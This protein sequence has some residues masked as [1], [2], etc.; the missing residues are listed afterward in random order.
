MEVDTP[1][2]WNYEA[3][4]EHVNKQQI[5]GFESPLWSETISSSKD[6]EYLSFPRLMG[7]AEMGWS[8]PD[9]IDW[10]AYKLRLLKHYRKLDALGINYYKSPTVSNLIRQ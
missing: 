6:I 10:E 4:F 5:I 9:A 8:M 7:H 3:L 1:Y 2:G